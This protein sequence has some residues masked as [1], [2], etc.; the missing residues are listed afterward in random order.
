MPFNGIAA[1]LGVK[2]ATDGDSKFLSR[3]LVQ[4]LAE[5]PFPLHILSLFHSELSKKF[6]LYSTLAF[7][8]GPYSPTGFWSDESHLLAP[9]KW[10]F[11]TLTSPMGRDPCA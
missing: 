2:I 8:M 1:L 10:L 9:P 4:K 6:R 5:E 7:S 3:K 11:L